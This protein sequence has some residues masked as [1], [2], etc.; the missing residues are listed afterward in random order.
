MTPTTIFLIRHGRTH[1]NEARTL[2]GQLPGRLTD[3]GIAQGRRLAEKLHDEVF[4]AV[5]ASD[6]QRV[7]DTLAPLRDQ[8]PDLVIHE[9]TELR[10]RS[11]G[12]YQGR[13]IDAIDWDRVDRREIE[14]D[15]AMFDRAT[16]V[17]REVL[18]THP[19]GRVL[20]AGHGGIN[21]A[22]TSALL[23]KGRMHRYTFDNCN[24]SVFEKTVDHPARILHF[25][26]TDHL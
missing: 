14:T 9:R 4:D 17:V 16:R 24:Y 22:I 3:E 26:R 10:E 25:N 13:P 19:G 7:R 15:D 2:Q 23:H 12:V 1:E 21:S 6:L 5:Y 8:R 20:I 18:A 11:F